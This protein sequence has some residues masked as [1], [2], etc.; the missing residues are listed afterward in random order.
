M[1]VRCITES[2][3][4]RY[5][6]IEKGKIYEVTGYDNAFPNIYIISGRR[7]SKTYF[8]TLIKERARKLKLLGI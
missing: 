6:G 2:S 1:L 4:L 3:R 7:A 8:I 5:K